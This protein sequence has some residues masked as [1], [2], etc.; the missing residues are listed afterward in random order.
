MLR[1]LTIVFGILNSRRC[2]VKIR[3]I[4][5]KKPPPVVENMAL[6]RGG[7]LS[8]WKTA[9]ASRRYRKNLKKAYEISFPIRKPPPLVENMALTR[10]GAFLQ[11]GAFL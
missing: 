8:Y 1:F 11:E 4:P 2:R 5:Y 10:G 3:T 6:T 7:G 9:A